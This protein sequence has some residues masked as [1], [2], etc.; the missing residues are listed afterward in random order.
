MARPRI[1][2]IASSADSGTDS[3]L[4]PIGAEVARDFA[5]A[6]AAHPFLAVYTS[7]SPR[8]LATA[9]PIAE[10]LRLKAVER[11]GLKDIGY[12]EWEG[13]SAASVSGEFSRDYDRWRM[14]PSKYPPTGGEKA[15]DVADR[16]AK[17]IRELQTAFRSGEVLIVSH[18]ATIRILLCSLLGLN[19]ALFRHRL[20]C[21][22]GSVSVLAASAQGFQLCSLADCGHLTGSLRVPVPSKLRPGFRA[23]IARQPCRPAA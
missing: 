4:S 8:A 23:A 13:R 12:G 17:V 6:Y 22:A 16:A 10:A 21:P 19:I 3:A 5:S 2:T 1:A 11:D 20:A 14:N 7:P 18:A 15:S 9:L